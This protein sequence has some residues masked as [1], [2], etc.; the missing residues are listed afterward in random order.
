MFE[1]PLKSISFLRFLLSYHFK[2]FTINANTKWTQ[3]Q[4][5]LILLA[6][7]QQ[8]DDGLNFW[9]NSVSVIQCPTSLNQYFSF[10]LIDA[11]VLTLNGP[12]YSCS[13]LFRGNVMYLVFSL[14]FLKGQVS[15]SH[16]HH[17]TSIHTHVDTLTGI[18]PMKPQTL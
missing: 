2:R 12:L 9:K 7:N 15:T 10:F 14:A 4:S 5:S 3:F 1:I 16:T 6:M 17:P 8:H 11:T 13:C 18:W